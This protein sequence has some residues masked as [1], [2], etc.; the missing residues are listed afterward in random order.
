V[1]PIEADIGARIETFQFLK[2]IVVVTI[3]NLAREAGVSVGTVSHD[4]RNGAAMR[5]GI[6]A[7]VL[8]QTPAAAERA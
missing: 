6:Q 7:R 8:A 4:L 3:E 1:Q 2:F 5:S